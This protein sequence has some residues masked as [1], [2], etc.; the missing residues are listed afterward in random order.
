MEH[1]IYY[2]KRF[3]SHSG[4]ILYFNLLGMVFVSFLQGMEIFL[5]L[6]LLSISGIMGTNVGSNL[7]AIILK[8]LQIPPNYLGLPLIL[9]VYILLV[10]AQNLLQRDIFRRNVKLHLSFTLHLRLE[11]YRQIL[12]ANW[13]FFTKK[14]KSD[15]INILTMEMSRVSVGLSLCLQLLTNL[16]FSL[17]Q[18]AI[19]FWLSISLTFFVL[20]SGF[21]LALLNRRFVK[22]AK[23]LGSLSSEISKNYIACMTDQLNGI[24]E[25]KSNT[26]EVSSMR[27]MQSLTKKM[28][29]EQQEYINMRT[30]SEF[31][32]KIAS[33]VL[34]VVCIYL[35]VLLLHAKP[36]QLLLIIIIFTRLWPRFT[37]VQANVENIA[38]NFSSFR[39][40]SELEKECQQA[41][42]LKETA[43]YY[44][45]TQLIRIEQSL[46]CRNVYFRYNPQAPVYALQEISLQI[47]ANCMTAIVGRSGAGKST[48][49][50]ILMGLIQPEEGQIL[51]DGIP[52]TNDNVLALRRA[53][54]YVPQDPF[55]FNES[56]RDNLLLIRPTATEAELWEALEFSAAAE[57]V[58]RLPKGLDTH[59]GDRGVRLSGG[60]RQR[61]VLARAILRKPA[62]LVLDEATSA[63]DSENELKI[64]E[65]LERIKGKMTI[66]V[67]AH[68]L[69]TIRNADQVIVIE[70][71]KVIQRGGFNQLAKEKRGLFHN[72]LE[73]QTGVNL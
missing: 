17:I 32:S 23:Q 54:S 34:V 73:N 6:P 58:R 55:L 3:S 51:I 43:Q 13:D 21:G 63:L 52:L 31:V 41:K 37:N 69:S 9:G 72:L 10:V 68:R 19:A 46:E 25:V 11:T 38:S 56:I 60:E 42:E 22:K 18:I 1:L 47:P 61:L 48:L 26:L 44:E 14:R 2:F 36:A 65:A 49:I 16:I 28:E 29:H 27:W 64:Q 24:K 12:Q 70:Q 30:N 71:G 20:I 62:V 39:I 59:I 4:K 40:L 15:L 57:F 8:S 33:A 67:I 66:I 53:I 7:I 5:L 35:S 45:T 50:D